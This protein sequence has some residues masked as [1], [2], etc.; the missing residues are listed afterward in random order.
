MTLL[1]R[2]PSGRDRGRIR[3]R[4]GDVS[5]MAAE[6]RRSRSSTSTPTRPRPSP[7]RST[8]SR[9]RSMSPTTTRSRPRC[10]M[11]PRR[12]ADCRSCTTRG[13]KHALPHPRLR[14][15]RVAPD[16]RSQPHGVF[17]GFKAA[18]R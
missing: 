7:R 10:P 16:R 11:R 6:A 8:A 4:R 17:H 9:T 5:R 3:H 1:E 14:S 13:R 2:T 12:W 15:R 18:R